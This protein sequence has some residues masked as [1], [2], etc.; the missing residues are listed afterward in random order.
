MIVCSCMHASGSS[1]ISLEFIHFLVWIH[2]FSR[3]NSFIISDFMIGDDSFT[4]YRVQGNVL[5]Q[6]VKMWESGSLIT[7]VFGIETAVGTVPS[8]LQENDSF[9]FESIEV[10][11]DDL[12]AFFHGPHKPFLGNLGV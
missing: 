2:S 3:S 6:M 9:L 4:G 5:F 10:V 7:Q 12:L 1:I 11:A 8:L